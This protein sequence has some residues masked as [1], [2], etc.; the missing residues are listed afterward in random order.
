MYFPQETICADLF[1]G[2][3]TIGI[4]CAKKTGATVYGVEIN[5]DAVKDAKF[6]A[7]LN[8]VKNIS[9][10]ATD[11]E[12]FKKSVDVAIIDPPRKGCST[13]MLETLMRLKPERI[14]YVSCNAETLVRDLK[15]LLNDYSMSSPVYTYNMFP[16]TSHVESVI[17]LT[18]K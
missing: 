5:E 6:N 9:F 15:T 7:K 10:E 16:R 11:A 13:F 18:R 14:V 8:G 12:N 17:S 1:C 3:G 4:I 2:T